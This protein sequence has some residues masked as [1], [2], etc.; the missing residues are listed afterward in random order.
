MRK[1]KRLQ[2]TYQIKRDITTFVN[3]YMNQ[4]EAVGN[5]IAKG[6]LTILKH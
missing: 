5:P 4:V 3:R 2:T 6:G 1:Q